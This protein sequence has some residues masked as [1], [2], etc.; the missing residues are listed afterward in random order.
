MHS[1]KDNQD[2]QWELNLTIGSVR[3]VKG[4]L[5]INLLEPEAGEPPLLTRLGTDEMLLVDVIFCLCKPQADENNI[6]DEQFGEGLGG[7]AILAAQQAFYDELVDFFRKRGRTDRA[8]AVMKQAKVIRMAVEKV[9]TIVESLDLESEM[10]K[11]L[12]EAS[13]NSLE[14]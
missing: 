2:R 12:K 8:T 5:D 14:S 1:F 4:L 10:D 13:G 11:A 6:S 3:R 7:E 9:T